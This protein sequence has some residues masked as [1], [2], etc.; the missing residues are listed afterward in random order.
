[1]D[2]TVTFFY[3]FVLILLSCYTCFILVPLPPTDVTLQRSPHKS[4]TELSASW[5]VP[6]TNDENVIYKVRLEKVKSGENS[7]IEKKTAS[8]KNSHSFTG[9]VPG[10][11][12]QVHVWS[13][14][15]D[16]TDNQQVKSV[17]VNNR[18]PIYTSK[19]C[20]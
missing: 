10:G 18:T 2:V 8:A 5:K 14:A 16:G 12:Y 4:T 13:E 7:E 15:G 17:E 6:S 11:R 1:M 3:H 20:R 19:F 9:L